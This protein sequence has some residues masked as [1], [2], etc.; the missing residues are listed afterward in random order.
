LSINDVESKIKIRLQWCPK[1]VMV[2]Y[3]VPRDKQITTSVLPRTE[4]TLGLSCEEITSRK[5]HID[6][7]SIRS[8]C[9]QPTVDKVDFSPTNCYYPSVCNR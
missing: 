5:I 3:L 1:K 2:S 8:F 4:P 7:L 9:Y 6:K